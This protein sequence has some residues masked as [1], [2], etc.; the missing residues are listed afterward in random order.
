M[1][2]MF[3]ILSGIWHLLYGISRHIIYMQANQ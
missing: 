1:K 2:Y 3:P